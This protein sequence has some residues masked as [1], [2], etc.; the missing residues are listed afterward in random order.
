MFI[1]QN[2]K[3]A[4]QNRESLRTFEIDLKFVLYFYSR[5]WKKCLDC[6]HVWVN[7]LIESA[8]LRESRNLQNLSPAGSYFHVLCMECLSHIALIP[9]NLPSPKK[10]PGCVPG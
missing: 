9:R 4:H 8:V 1:S 5:F 3:I 2:A 7:F 10:I 6:V